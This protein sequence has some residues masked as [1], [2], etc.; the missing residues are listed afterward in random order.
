MQESPSKRQRIDMADALAPLGMSPPVRPGRSPRPHVPPPPRMQEALR[1]V[2]SAGTLAHLE[3]ERRV[4]GREAVAPTHTRRIADALAHANWASQ[5]LHGDAYVS[6]T[7]DLP[8]MM[9]V[10]WRLAGRPVP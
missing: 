7:H 1:S 5:Q 8:A 9:Y 10:D 4:V 6:L 3:L 2:V